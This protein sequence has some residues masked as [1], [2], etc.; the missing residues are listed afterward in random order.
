MQKDTIDSRWMDD[1]EDDMTAGLTCHIEI[2]NEGGDTPREVATST[3]KALR[4]LA[5]Q[6]EAGTLEDGHH[7]I[8]LL[9]GKE[10]G[11]VYIDWYASGSR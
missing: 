9:D 1:R 4:A 5:A 10:I 6:I 3:A 8:S 7:P 2:D 11:E